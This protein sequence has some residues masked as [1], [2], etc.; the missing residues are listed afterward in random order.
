[1]EKTNI[2]ILGAKGSIGRALLSTIDIK[3]YNILSQ[4]RNGKQIKRGDIPFDINDNEKLEKFIECSDIVVNCIAPSYKY[5]EK[6]YEIAEKY[7]KQFIDPFGATLISL[8][9]KVGGVI[10]S[11]ECPGF[12]A[13]ILKYIYK[14]YF[15]LI[16]EIEFYYKPS[17]ELSKQAMFDFIRS[18]E[19]GFGKV[20]YYC[21]NRKEIGSK[22]RKEKVRIKNHSYIAV[23]FITK[24]YLELVK[25]MDVQI[26][27]FKNLFHSEKQLEDIM[28]CLMDGDDLID[29]DRES[30]YDDKFTYYIKCLGIRNGLY[31]E[32]E[33]EVNF[34]SSNLIS[35]IVINEIIHLIDRKGSIGKWVFPYQIIDCAS[36]VEELI[37]LNIIEIKEFHVEMV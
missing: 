30:K 22:K 14:N 31:Q 13:V 20:G 12:T 33:Y 37:K 8:D 25:D 27:K 11:G 17:G 32:I 21:M 10:L 23:D 5:S 36:F 15:D 19:K 1:M 6:I 28:G 9:T 26:L 4:C 29:I 18:A 16:S 7:D 2:G 35:A 24:E 34:T 3:K